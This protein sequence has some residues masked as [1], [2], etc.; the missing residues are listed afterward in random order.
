[1][2]VVATTVGRV[3]DS[4]AMGWDAIAA[5]ATAGAAAVAVGIWRV[6]H[7]R[8]R[9]ARAG[10]LTARL[11]QRRTRELAAGQWRDTP[12]T[13]TCLVVRNGAD[14]PAYDVKVQEATLNV[15]PRTVALLPP[16]GVEEVRAAD[17]IL[18]GHR[19]DGIGLDTQFTMDERRW[20]ID[21]TGRLSGG[22]RDRGRP[23]PT[24]TKA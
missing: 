12:Y 9:R 10:R 4:W 6:D 24:V 11:E 13:Y 20:H 7:R 16:G 5:L 14:A 22:R 19:G 23:D 18:A 1:M 8:A 21:A 17:E 2:S 15:D 3:G